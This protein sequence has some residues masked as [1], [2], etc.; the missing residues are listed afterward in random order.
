MSVA[1][2]R[3]DVEHS[4]EAEARLARLEERTEHIQGDVAEV[5]G[6]LR[7]LDVK[8]DAVKDLVV[9]LAEKVAAFD[10]KLSAME[11]SIIKWM[12]G[13]VIAAAALAFAIAKFVS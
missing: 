8:L 11:V 10:G 13:T 5:K 7:R 3:F 4:M 1:A 2:R 12:V 6:D 9:S